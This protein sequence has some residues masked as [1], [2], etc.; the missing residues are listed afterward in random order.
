VSDE[1]NVPTDDLAAGEQVDGVDGAEAVVLSDLDLAMYRDHQVT[2]KINGE[3][4]KVP[5]AEAVAGY[6][7]QA[8]YTVKTQEL[9]KQTDQLQWATAMRGALDNDPQGTIDLLM[10]HYGVSRAAAA[11][12]VADQWSEPADPQYESLN[13]RIAR[14]EEA[15]A[16]ADLHAEVARLQSQ[17]G[18]DF[19]AREVVAAALERGSTDLEATFKLVS[20]DRL[21]ERQRTS[22]AS[23]AANAASTVAKQVGGLVAGGATPQS[24]ASDDTPIRSISDAYFA[25]KREYGA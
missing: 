15:Q 21:V 10:Q 13:A 25:A 3:E 9:A 2:V 7:R 18:D 1:V 14:F 4:R 22:S 16:T 17:Y 8:D 5:L 19:D 11:E 20:F 6:Q 24:R 12:T 23:A